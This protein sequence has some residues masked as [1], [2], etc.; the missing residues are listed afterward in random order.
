MDKVVLSEFN[1]TNCEEFR[2]IVVDP[3]ARVFIEVFQQS[4]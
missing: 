4:T 2:F 1:K 3:K